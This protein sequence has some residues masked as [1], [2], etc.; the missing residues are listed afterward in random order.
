M[1]LSWIIEHDP[2]TL[3]LTCSAPPSTLTKKESHSSIFLFTLLTHFH[4]RTFVW[5]Q[6]MSCYSWWQQASS[7]LPL[8][9]SMQRCMQWT[10]ASNCHSHLSHSLWHRCEGERGGDDSM[11]SCWH[12]WWCCCH[13]WRQ[14]SFVMMHVQIDS[15]HWGWLNDAW[16]VVVKWSWQSHHWHCCCH[17]LTIPLICIKEDCVHINCSHAKEWKSGCM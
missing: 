10:S 15:N 6:E 14:C 13:W 12:P 7:P 8:S 11:L 9:V 2:S 16:I 17:A 5:Y 1:H 4:S 3:S